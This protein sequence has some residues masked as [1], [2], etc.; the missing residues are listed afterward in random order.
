MRGADPIDARLHDERLENRRKC[1]HAFPW[2]EL[3]PGAYAEIDGV[4]HIVLADSVRPWSR[5]SG[6]GSERTRPRSGDARLIT[7]PSTV[8]AILAGYVPQV[9]S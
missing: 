3:P 2:R 9:S 4:P 7:P 5:E 8:R 1:L 6:Y